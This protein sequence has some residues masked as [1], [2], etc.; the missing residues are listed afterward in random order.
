[1]IPIPLCFPFHI[2]LLIDFKRN[3][4]QALLMPIYRSTG[5]S[6]DQS[7]WRTKPGLCREQRRDALVDV[8]AGFIK[9]L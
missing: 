5:L 7:Q 1:M 8:S 3:E 9:P 2:R 6:F 4:E